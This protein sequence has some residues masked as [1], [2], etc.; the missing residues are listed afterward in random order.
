ME[1]LLAQ[2]EN[3]F[4]RLQEDLSFNVCDA[5][6]S[7]CNGFSIFVVRRH[8]KM[9][10][11]FQLAE[12]IY[13]LK[14]VFF[15]SGLKATKVCIFFLY[16]THVHCISWVLTV[17]PVQLLVHWT[18]FLCFKLAYIK[19]QLLVWCLPKTGCFTLIAVWVQ[20]VPTPQPHI[21][22]WYKNIASKYYRS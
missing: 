16:T 22:V 11:A 6:A 1:Y 17:L 8:E 3:C 14:G 4:F 5:R 12:I 9:K 2:W 21:R 7:A 18:Q 19:A 20:S 10:F 15:I 13:F